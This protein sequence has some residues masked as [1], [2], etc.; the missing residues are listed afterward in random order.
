MIIFHDSAQALQKAWQSYL[1]ALVNHSSLSYHKIDHIL[2]LLLVHTSSSPYWNVSSHWAGTVPY[3]SSILP[4][5]RNTLPF[6]NWS[7]F[8]SKPPSYI[9]TYAICLSIMVITP[10]LLKIS[11]THPSCVSFKV[12]SAINQSWLDEWNG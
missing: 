9:R 1:W 2:L 11:F 7:N 8:T 5:F 3:L 4:E 12:T 10:T 6:I